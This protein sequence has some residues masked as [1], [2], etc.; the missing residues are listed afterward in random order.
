MILIDIVLYS[1]QPLL[2]AGLRAALAE[3]DGFQLAAVCPTVDHLV[4]QFRATPA[5][6]VL[7]EMT[8]E[9]D[10]PL[11]KVIQ[12]ESHGAPIVLWVRTLSTEFASQVI[13]MGVRGILRAT[14]PIELQIKCLRKV[15]EGQLWIE[16]TLSDRLLTSNR[17]PLTHRER[18][19]M[20][21]LAQGLKNKEIAYALGVTEGT[22]KVYLSHLFR[23]VGAS[24]RLELA[25]FALRNIAASGRRDATVAREPGAAQATPLFVPGFVSQPAA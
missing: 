6:I 11:L 5:T 13:A 23:K 25:L 16:K 14:L 3:A 8:P 1:T 21:L 20:G 4:D 19:L 2:A 18:Q 15:A 22:V 12:S 7:I 24:D 9:V 17:V 10:L